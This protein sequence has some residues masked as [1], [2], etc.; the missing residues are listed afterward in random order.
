MVSDL[1][2]SAVRGLL[3]NAVDKLGVQSWSFVITLLLARILS[4][5]D[6]GLIGMLSIFMAVSQVLIDSGMSSGLIQKKDRKPEDYDTVFVFNFAVSALIYLIIFF[7]P[8]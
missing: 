6:F 4:P 1:K 2:N 5:D 3:W 7:Q 8:P